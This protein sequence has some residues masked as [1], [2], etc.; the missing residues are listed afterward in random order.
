MIIFLESLGCCR[1][2]VDSEVMLGRLAEAGHGVVHDPA[3]ADVII[4]NTCGFISA[5]SAEAVDTILA[6][7][8]YKQDGRCRRLVVTGC[9][10][11][12]FKDDDLRGELPE[13]DAFVGTGACDEIVRVVESTEFMSLL[14]DVLDRQMQGHP[15]PRRITLDY[16][17]YVKISEGCNRH[18]TYCII[19]KLRG[20][21]RSRTVAAVVAE[22]E[23]L[24]RNGAREIVLVGENTSDYG[25]DLDGA[26]SGVNI[27]ILLTTLSGRIK[28]L[29]PDVWIRLLYTHPS[30]LDQNAI[31]AIADLDN[32][33][34]YF[35]VPIQHASSRILRRMGRNYTGEDLHGLIASIRR[36]A[37][38]AALRTTLITGFPGETEADFNEMLAFVKATG[39]DQLGVFAYSDSDDLAAHSL[40]DHVDEE[41]GEA[42]RDAI[43]AAQAE[44]SESINESYLGK[45]LTVLVEENPDPGIFIGRTRFQAPEVD[46]ITF[47]YGNNIDIGTFVRVKITETH[48]Y[49]LVGELV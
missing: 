15:L 49:D 25:M 40:A 16:L 46:G 33:C 18:C 30:S 19:P 29:D 45:T 43:M 26:D 14:P 1:N 11:E 12:R 17:A 21:Q 37:P 42:R 10:P 27:A 8:E 41:T 2:L 36:T 39:F 44:I 24:V 7:A 47:I 35:D 31:R 20:I 32:V 23:I 38:D 3:E 6:M 13:V 28:A 4:V 9:L 22:S 48:A 5:A 34:T